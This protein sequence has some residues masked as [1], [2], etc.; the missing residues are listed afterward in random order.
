MQM[1]KHSRG[2]GGGDE[3]Q[4]ARYNGVDASFHT[5]EWHAARLAALQM[6]RPSWDDWKKQQ[7]EAAAR[8]AA[9]EAATRD[10][11]LQYKAEM[12]AERSR[13]LGLTK[14]GG[15]KKREGKEGKKEKKSK[16]RKHK[17]KD[18]KKKHKK[19]SKDKRSKKKKRRHSSSSSSSSSSDSD[20]GSSSS[21][22]ADYG[23]M[24]SPVRLS[25]FLNA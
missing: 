2:T 22:Q 6:E 23:G 19:S 12:E 11:D 17:S 4:D 15:V 3:A 16:K 10:A 18:S 7:D 14:E 25:K 21:D 9:M 24:G 5:T 13:R 20:S 8:E 1:Q